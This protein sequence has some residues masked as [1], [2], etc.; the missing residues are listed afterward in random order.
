MVLWCL[1][2]IATVSLHGQHLWQVVPSTLSSKQIDCCDTVAMT[3]DMYSMATILPLQTHNV[4]DHISHIICNQCWKTWPKYRHMQY[5]LQNKG[6]PLSPHKRISVSSRL[7]NIYL[8]WDDHITTQIFRNAQKPWLEHTQQKKQECPIQEY[9]YIS[10]YAGNRLYRLS[11]SSLSSSPF[12]NAV[13]WPSYK[14]QLI[15]IHFF[16]AT[17]MRFHCTLSSFQWEFMKGWESQFSK[18]SHQSNCVV[19]DTYLEDIMLT[20]SHHAN[21]TQCMCNHST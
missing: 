18:N 9:P 17:R 16:G 8:S 13:L 19:K 3:H 15:Q 14:Q 12:P 10:M 4:G 2:H 11:S 6:I 1:R 21:P 7:P 20:K 5:F